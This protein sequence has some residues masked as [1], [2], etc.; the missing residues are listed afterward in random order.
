MSLALPAAVVLELVGRPEDA[1]LLEKHRPA[2]DPVFAK[3]FDDAAAVLRN[4]H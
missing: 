2:D 4:L 3:V 1:A